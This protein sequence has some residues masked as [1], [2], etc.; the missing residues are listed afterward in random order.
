M[1]PDSLRWW[2]RR[3]E[4]LGEE[5]CGLRL[6][7]DG[8]A[9]GPLAGSGHLWMTGKPFAKALC[10]AAVL[11]SATRAFFG[12]GLNDSPPIPDEEVTIDLEG[13]VQAPSP[14]Y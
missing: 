11:R 2:I 13:Q 4:S 7:R 8:G 3:G 1:A 6:S 12:C 14:Q 10:T 5:A 9:T